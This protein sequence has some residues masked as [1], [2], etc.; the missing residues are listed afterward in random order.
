MNRL[1]DLTGMTVLVVGGAQCDVS[2]AQADYVIAASS[3]VR[4]VPNA[5]M[6]VSID[7]MIPLHRAGADRGFNGIRVSGVPSDDPAHIYVPFPYEHVHVGPNRTVHVRNNG[8]SAIRLAADRGATRILLAGFAPAE[9]DSFN[10]EHGYDGVTAAAIP[11]LIAELA[12]RGIT[13]EFYTAPA[14]DKPRWSRRG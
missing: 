11:A 14:A 8:I 10:A 9:Y 12:G 2:A 6:L 7:N 4:H 3:G 5:N 1:P 13:V